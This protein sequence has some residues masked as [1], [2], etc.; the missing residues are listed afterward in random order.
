MHML[1]P[2]TATEVQQAGGE[3]GRPAQ[4]GAVNASE[5]R[6]GPATGRQSLW[7]V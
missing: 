4:K 2:T 7:C 1:T 6:A 5:G 3:Q